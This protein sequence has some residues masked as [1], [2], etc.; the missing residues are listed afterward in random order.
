MPTTAQKH[1]I[2]AAVVETQE[3]LKKALSY[4]PK[5]QNQDIIKFY[6]RHIETLQKMLARE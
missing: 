5:F 1:R 2:T 6:R 3:L 4:Q